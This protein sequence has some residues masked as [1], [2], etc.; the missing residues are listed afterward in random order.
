M[1][2]KGFRHGDTSGYQRL[3]WF[4][5]LPGKCHS[6]F[7][8]RR[9]LRTSHRKSDGKNRFFLS[10]SFILERKVLVFQ[11]MV[12]HDFSARGHPRYP[13]L[14]PCFRATRSAGQFENCGHG[15]ILNEK[16]E[17]SDPSRDVGRQ[18]PSSLE[19]VCAKNGPSSRF[20]V[21]DQ[22]NHLHSLSKA[23]D[24]RRRRGR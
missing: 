2:I 9:P 4:L 23:F 15:I 13:L 8:G 18:P 17:R 6:S 11:Q 5:P 24:T 1:D 22:F 12:D 19:K 20:S 7:P 10:P 14:F 16:I 3:N 21:R